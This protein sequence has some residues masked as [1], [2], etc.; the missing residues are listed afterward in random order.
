MELEINLIHL[1]LF[2]ESQ[3]IAAECF[4]AEASEDV[5]DLPEDFLE[6]LNI[7]EVT[8]IRMRLSNP[9]VQPARMADLRMKNL[10][11]LTKKSQRYISLSQ[12]CYSFHLVLSHV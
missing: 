2:R 6:K 12:I 1:D 10:K 7:D 9:D 4:A 5:D 3:K 11:L 8:K